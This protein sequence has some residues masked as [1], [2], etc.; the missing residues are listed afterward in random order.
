[1]IDVRFFGQLTDRTGCNTVSLED[2]L[3]TDNLIRQL[4]ERFPALAGAKFMLAVDNK[5][6]QA[7]SILSDGCRVDLLPPFSGG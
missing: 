1:M 5:M 3:D 6:I 7:N 2:P 4:N